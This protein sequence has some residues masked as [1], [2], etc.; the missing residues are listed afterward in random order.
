MPEH[1]RIKEAH[2]IAAKVCAHPGII[3]ELC[4]S[5]DPD[6]IT[7]YVAAKKLGYQRIAKMKNAGDES[8][9]RIFFTDGSIDTESCIH[10]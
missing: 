9:R 6:Y 1:S 5:D 10:F 4:W 3:A 2:A 8:G 7:G